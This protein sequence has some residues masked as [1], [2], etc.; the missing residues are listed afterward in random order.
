MQRYYD[1]RNKRLVY[2]G[3]KI[4][5]DSWDNTWSNEI[6]DIKEI[7]N[8]RNNW[9]NK[10]TEKYIKPED[11][12]ILDGGCGIGDNVASLHNANYRI[13]GIDFAK[14]TVSA[15]NSYAP[16]LDIRYGDVQELEF[17]DREFV[18]YWSL[19]VIGH[20]WEGY[21][22]IAEEIHR[23]LMDKGY[24]FL[25]FPYMSPLRKLKAALGLYMIW[26]HSND[27][28]VNFT[29]FIFDKDIVTCDFE[30]AGFHLITINVCGGLKGLKDEISIIRKPLQKLFDYKGESVFVR[31]L[32][33]LI[34]LAT[35]H[36][37]SHQILLIFQK[38]G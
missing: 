33:K 12:L 27:E 24:L 25:M 18:A 36:F 32:S 37:A 29:E 26:N 1:K 34:S 28:V 13:I 21:H 10:I 35:R 20:F 16:I 31:F 15:L 7:V 23:V 8:I 11:G 2:M 19:G 5:A 17:G 38:S 30:S 4:D 14:H 6:R 3:R 9:V 22:R